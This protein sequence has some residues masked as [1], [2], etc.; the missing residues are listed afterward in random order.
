[1]SLDIV[2]TMR[3][4]ISELVRLKLRRSI[5]I[6]W[7]T[8]DWSICVFKRRTRIYIHARSDGTSSLG[9][10]SKFCGR[11]FCDPSTNYYHSIPTMSFELVRTHLLVYLKDIPCGNKEY[12][13]TLI[14]GIMS[15]CRE[16]HILPGTGAGVK[17]VYDD[18]VSIFFFFFCD[19]S[20]F[21]GSSHSSVELHFVLLWAALVIYEAWLADFS[22]LI[23]LFVFGVAFT[24]GINELAPILTVLCKIN[25][26]NF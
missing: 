8:D 15:R 10:K 19:N 13:S 22:R 2:V 26:T 23:T 18:I 9:W 14:H 5:P 11:P 24:F 7:S 20:S 16:I 4:E 12:P 3:N 17:R 21:L 25:P 1:M 6:F